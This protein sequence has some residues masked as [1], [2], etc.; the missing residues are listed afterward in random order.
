MSRHS[1]LHSE[2]NGHTDSDEALR[3]AL[4]VYAGMVH[5]ILANPARWLGL[6]EDPPPSAPL[7]ARVIDAVRDRAFGQITPAS[8][9]WD[10]LPVKKRID[11]WVRR[12]TISAGLAAAAPRLAGALA[13]RIP[14]QSALGAAASGLAVCAVAREYGRTDPAEWVP[15]LAAVLFDCTITAQPGAVPAEPESE[16]RLISG[17]I[18]R[19]S[20]AEAKTGTAA[21]GRGARRAAQSVW[22]LARSFRDLHHLLGNRPRGS[23]LARSIAQLPVI[24]IAGGWLDERGG[25]R[26]AAKHTSRLL[27]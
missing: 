13:D 15:L 4:A 19:H 25:I 11:W 9:Q 27:R 26:K 24:G 14:L 20:D 23:L 3:H 1:D 17:P 16:D 5:Q 22:Q 10:Q 18:N 12:I 6:D 2:S 8:P 21:Q 7:P